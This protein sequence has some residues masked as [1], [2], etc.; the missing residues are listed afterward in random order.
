MMATWTEALTAA[1][2]V[3]SKGIQKVVPMAPL[4]AAWM[5]TPRAEMLV[6]E[7]VDKLDSLKV[8][9]RDK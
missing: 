1:V 6:V 3:A 8:E 2:M 5:A 7:T 9:Q 4:M